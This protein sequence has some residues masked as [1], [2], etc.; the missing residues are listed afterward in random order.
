MTTYDEQFEQIELAVQISL[1]NLGTLL[2]TIDLSERKEAPRL[3]FTAIKSSPAILQTLIDYFNQKEISLDTVSVHGR[4]AFDD[5]C[6]SGYHGSVELLIKGGANYKRKTP[7]LNE[8]YLDFYLKKNPENQTIISDFIKQR[9]EKIAHE[10]R[11][12]QFF[13][14]K[15]FTAYFDNLRGDKYKRINTNNDVI[16]QS[17]SLS[18]RPS[19]DKDKTD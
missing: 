15:F 16:R 3:L 1:D 17:S 13:L 14:T 6:V 2:K 11:P 5:A 10:T 9:E 19:S 18:L 4:T 12:Q 7:S 8:T